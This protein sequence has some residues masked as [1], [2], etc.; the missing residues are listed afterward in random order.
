M[1]SDRC[2][3]QKCRAKGGGKEVKVQEFRYRDITNVELE[4]YD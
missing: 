4:M 1:H 3:R 2:G